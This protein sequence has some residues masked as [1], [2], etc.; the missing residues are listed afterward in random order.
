[1]L[2]KG[3]AEGVDVWIGV[4]DL[5]DGSEDAG[6]GFE[7]L[8]GEIADIIVLD[9]AV[10]ESLEVEETRVSVPQDCVT[11]A[12]DHSALLESLFNKLLDDGLAGFLSLVVVLELSEPLEAFLIGEAVE[13]ACEP[14]HGGGECEIGVGE[15]GANEL[16]GVGGDVASLVVGVDGE[17]SSDALLHL[18]VVEAEHV[19]EVACPVE[20]VI[21]FD[22]LRVV[23]LVAVDG[24]ADLW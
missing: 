24:S 13:G 20:R 19:R 2:Q 4:F 5:S 7:A 11:V 6:D 12:G 15:C 14:V 23:V 9:V 1:M 3:T 22:E 16:G 18:V 21:G 8:A 17:V 10:S